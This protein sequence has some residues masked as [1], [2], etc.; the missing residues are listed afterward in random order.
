MKRT[1]TPSE[2]ENRLRARAI[3]ETQ[4]LLARDRKRK[5]QYRTMA[6][7]AG[8][9]LVLLAGWWA[10]TN[11]AE[12][13]DHPTFADY[14]E[15]QAAPTLEGTLGE[16]NIIL[17]QQRMLRKAYQEKDYAQVV[18]IG[19]PLLV[20][21][22]EEAS[23]NEDWLLLYGYSLGQEGRKQEALAILDRISDS[24]NYHDEAEWQSILL[25][26]K[27]Y[28]KNRS[29]IEQL[30]SISKNVYHRYQQKAEELMELL[31]EEC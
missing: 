3:Q 26:L 19:G 22:S 5:L 15:N 2:E 29:S 27:E 16:E 13:A 23:A 20:L 17:E 1:E 14:I 21:L 7:A 18:E 28:P 31:G 10:M 12:T 8:F 24:S 9:M 4:M 25:R 6:I 30:C 11:V